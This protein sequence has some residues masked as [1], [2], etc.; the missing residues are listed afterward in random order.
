MPCGTAQC[1][2]SGDTVND[3]SGGGSSEP[4]EWHLAALTLVLGVCEASDAESDSDGGAGSSVDQVVVDCSVAQQV[5]R[6]RWLSAIQPHEE[7]PH[8]CLRWLPWRVGTLIHGAMCGLRSY[9]PNSPGRF[10]HAL[11]SILP[12]HRRSPGTWGEQA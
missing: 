9:S 12:L 8:G 4:S 5:R 6:S 3:S 1:Q 7:R 10:R 11:G 2:V